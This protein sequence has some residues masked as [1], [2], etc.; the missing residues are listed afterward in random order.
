MHLKLPDLSRIHTEFGDEINHSFRVR[1]CGSVLRTTSRAG[2][3][4]NT[5]PLSGPYL[6][7]G[8][9][10]SVEIGEQE[11]SAQGETC[12]M[13]PS[14]MSFTFGKNHYLLFFEEKK[15]IECHDKGSL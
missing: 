1:L 3:P 12:V 14:T 15:N 5:D 13:T 9:P 6:I 8:S 10:S 7:Q 2:V 11:N 4:Q